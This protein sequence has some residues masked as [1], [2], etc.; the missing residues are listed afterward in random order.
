MIFDG[1]IFV[2]DQFVDSELTSSKKKEDVQSHV[3]KFLSSIY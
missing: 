1:S 2:D 3:K